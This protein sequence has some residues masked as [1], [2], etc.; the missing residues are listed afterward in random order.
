VAGLK[1]QDKIKIEFTD[2]VHTVLVHTV[3]VHT[4]LVHT[5]LDHTAHIIHHHLSIMVVRHHLST[6]VE[7]TLLQ[8]DIFLLMHHPTVSYAMKNKN[9]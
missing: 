4:V 6:M 2:L 1:D 7:L 8:E 3:L 5:V 9:D